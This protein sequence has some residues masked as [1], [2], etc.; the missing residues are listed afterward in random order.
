MD[1]HEEVFEKSVVEYKKYQRKMEMLGVEMF[2]FNLIPEVN[3]I[4][5]YEYIEND[6]SYRRIEIP[7]FV[8][9]L[10]VGIFSGVKQNLKVKFSN[11]NKI[12][13]FMGVFM[14]YRGKELDLTEFNTEG[15]LDMSLMFQNCYELEQIRGI[16]KF[17]VNLDDASKMFIGCRRLRKLDLRNMTIGDADYANVNQMFYET[18]RLKEVLSNDKLIIDAWTNKDRAW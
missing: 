1:Y 11:K 4:E 7:D 12:D 10:D 14:M 18:K 5:L 8:T 17:K 16:E 9:D 13:N 3:S 15:A 6:E 2:K